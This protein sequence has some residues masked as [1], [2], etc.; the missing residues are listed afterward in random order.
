[1]EFKSGNDESMLSKRT[2][3]KSKQDKERKR[4]GG[5]ALRNIN[6]WNRKWKQQE[7]EKSH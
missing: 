7:K 2:E 3:R 6:R 1:M 5:G 4:E